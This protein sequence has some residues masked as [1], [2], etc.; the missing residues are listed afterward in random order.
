MEGHDGANA[1]DLVNMTASLGQRLAQQG[2]SRTISEQQ[3][4]L[5]LGE[6]DVVASDFGARL[7]VGRAH[8]GPGNVEAGQGGAVGLVSGYLDGGK[9]APCEFPR[10]SA[11]RLSRSE[12][13]QCWRV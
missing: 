3:Q 5:R 13:F 4:A 6:T 1:L 11:N 2:L 8:P 9:H 10:F 7:A 12:V